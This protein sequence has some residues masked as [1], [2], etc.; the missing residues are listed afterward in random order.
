M[1]TE[2]QDPAGSAQRVADVM[3]ANARRLRTT[4][5]LT[6]D[7]VSIAARKR[8]LKWSE[9]RV[10]DFE[11]GRVAPSLTT[12]IA[13]VLALQ[14]AGC[15]KI[16]L[17]TLLRSATKIQI[18]DLL[19]L[20]DGQVIGLLGGRREQA[21]KLPG[22]K[23]EKIPKSAAKPKEHSSAIAERHATKRRA[24]PTTD[25]LPPPDRQAM[26][27]AVENASGATEERTRKALGIG[28]TELANL[29]LTL[30]N[31]TFSQERDR[32]AGRSANAQKRGQVS[33]QMRKELQRG[34]E[35]AAT[36]GDDK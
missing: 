9:A 30:W 11:A 19:E 14:D 18:N 28:K 8:G 4:A 31:R 21:P 7:E 16:R 6:L 15:G 34:M 20:N 1:G 36:N 12:L 17:D 33:R 13:V 27:A 24:A 29:S 22:E 23:Q 5:E 32:R 26:L 2:V 3:G 35:A 10:A 25:P